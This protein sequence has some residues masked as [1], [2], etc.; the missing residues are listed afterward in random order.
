MCV[1]EFQH[2]SFLGFMA[3]NWL[4]LTNNN[5]GSPFLFLQKVVDE[6]HSTRHGQILECQSSAMEKF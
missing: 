3:Q 5:S 4:A 6:G 1:C 2:I